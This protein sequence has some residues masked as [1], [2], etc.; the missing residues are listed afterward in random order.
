MR[1]A[2]MLFRVD[3]L[4]SAWAFT[5]QLRP[6][7]YV[8]MMTFDLNTHIVSDFT[9]DK[10]QILEGINELGNEVYMPAAFSGDQYLRCAERVA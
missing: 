8:A 1:R 6:Q 4:N 3:M 9:Q 10:K 5:Q 7:D 2:A